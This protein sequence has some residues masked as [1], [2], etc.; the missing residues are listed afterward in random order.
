MSRLF[1]IVIHV[2][3]QGLV[4]PLNWLIVLNCFYIPLSL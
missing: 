2:R 3:D 1:N 4:Y